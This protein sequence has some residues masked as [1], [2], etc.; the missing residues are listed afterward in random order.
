MKVVG[1]I[2]ESDELGGWCCTGD[3]SGASESGSEEELGGSYLNIKLGSNG[4]RRGFI[5]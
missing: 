3:S 4:T 2:S 5:R 1:S